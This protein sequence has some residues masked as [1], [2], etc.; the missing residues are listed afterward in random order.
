MAMAMA[1]SSYLRRWRLTATAALLLGASHAS[2]QAPDVQVALTGKRVVVTD[3]RE[4]LTEADKAKPGDVIQYEA[5]Y[6]NAGKGA[7]KGIA[8][9]VPV[10][11][12]MTFTPESAK[13]AGAQA[14]VDGKNFDAI[15]LMEDVKNAA[16]VVE[17]K[18]VPF[19][20][21]RAVRWLL[22]ELPPGEKATVSIRV[23]VLSNSVTE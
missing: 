18:Q 21:Y 19:P 17:K 7:A 22:P 23:R 12:G 4:S 6:R 15:P 16:G 20:R 3:G 5:I 2:G 1:M 8:A 10:P 13:P 14:S 9:T 11:Q